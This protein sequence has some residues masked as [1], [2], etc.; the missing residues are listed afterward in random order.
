[1][2]AVAERSSF[3]EIFEYLHSSRSK[4]GEDFLYVATDPKSS[5]GYGPYRMKVHFDPDTPVLVVSGDLEGFSS[6]H[7]ELKKSIE[8][9]IIG[10][11]PELEGCRKRWPEVKTN[12][13]L[14]LLAAEARG[15]GLIAYYGVDN[16][17]VGWFNAGYKAQWFQVL[18]SWA[19]KGMSQEKK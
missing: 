17:Q 11:Y 18:G 6:D 15:V 4:S 14:V 19:I 5:S 3:D 1:M 8:D 12:G 10:R 7:R 9:E 16:K 2:L 13:I